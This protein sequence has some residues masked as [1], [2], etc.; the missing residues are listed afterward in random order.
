MDQLPQELIELIVEF[1]SPDASLPDEDEDGW[2]PY[3]DSRKPESSL[4]PY[5]TIS[6]AWQAAIERQTFRSLKLNSDEYPMLKNT[7]GPHRYR[8]LQR[9]VLTI[10]L[11]SYDSVSATKVETQQDKDANDHAYSRAVHDIFDI[12]RSLEV[13]DGK[14]RSLEFYINHPVSRS[15]VQYFMGRGTKGSD[16][17]IY[18]GRYFHSYID[19]YNIHRLPKLRDVTKFVMKMPKTQL[20]HRMLYPRVPFQIASKMPNLEALS[21][22]ANDNERLYVDRRL[23]YRQD[24]AEHLQKLSL[25]KLRK[26]DLHFLYTSPQD[27]YYMPPMINP[28]ADFDLLSSVC[29]SFS[30][31]LEELDLNGVLDVTLLRPLEGFKTALWPRLEQLDIHFH[32]VRPAGGWYFTG[33]PPSWMPG[34]TPATEA[35]VDNP[36]E[37][38]DF[39]QEMGLIGMQQTRYFRTTPDNDAITPLVEA[40][41]DAVAVMPKIRNAMLHSTLGEGNVTPEWF[42]IAYVAPCRKPAACQ[43]ACY[44]LPERML[45]TDLQGWVPADRVTNKLRNMGSKYYDVD[46]TEESMDKFLSRNGRT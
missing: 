19:L 33:D 18:E 28:T 40:F 44:R 7:L 35:I 30:Q 6:R 41:A 5:A 26:A 37:E 21:V 29:Q 3:S 2:S 11:P 13:V 27:H 36:N 24:L 9:L 32:Q 31:G 17:Q 42:V 10:I 20:G 38:F 22:D 15:D 45:V 14:S 43:G 16:G 25:P 4:L 8:C 34:P 39:G 1:L 12:L 23:K 46:I